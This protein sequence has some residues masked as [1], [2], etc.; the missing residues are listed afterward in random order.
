M[1][2]AGPGKGSGTTFTFAGSMPY[3]VTRISLDGQSVAAIGTADLSL[4]AEAAD[5]IRTYE[6]GSVVDWGTITMDFLFDGA[7]ALL[8]PGVAAA[9]LSINVNAKD[10]ESIFDAD[11]YINSLSFEIPLE[12]EMTGTV[13]FR[14]VEALAQGVPA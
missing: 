12:A 11:C 13:V 1:A 4:Q 5:A 2:V 6:P 7:A 14:L 8:V 3:V 10:A 9:N